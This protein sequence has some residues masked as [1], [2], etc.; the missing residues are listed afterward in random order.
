[1]H[2]SGAVHPMQ[3]QKAKEVQKGCRKDVVFVW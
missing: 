3:Q 1:M 2:A